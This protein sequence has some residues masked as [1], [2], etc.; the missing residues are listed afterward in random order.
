[1]KVERYSIYFAN[2][3]PTQVGEMQ[4]NRPVVVISQNAMNENLETVVVCPITSKIHPKWQ[5]RLQILCQ[6]R[7][8]EI[9]MD[10]IRTISKSRIGNKVDKLSADEALQL[11]ALIT[12]MYGE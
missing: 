10:R 12:E 2:L 3:K 9:A 7:K 6:R 5:T 1:M 11:R 4:I 8:A